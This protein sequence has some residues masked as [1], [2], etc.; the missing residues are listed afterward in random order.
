V[1]ELALPPSEL[2]YVHL[3][4]SDQHF[5]AF[6]RDPYLALFEAGSFLC[7]LAGVHLYFG[8]DSAISKNRR[9]L[10]TLVLARWADQRRQ[11]RNAI[12]RDIIPPGDFNLPKTEPGD[13]IYDQLTG[14]GLQLP[15]HSTQIGSSIATESHYYQIAFFPGET[16]QQLT[17]ESGVFDFDG[18]LVRTLWDE[19]PE[20]DFLAYCRYYISDHRPL[21]AEFAI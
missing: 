15:E 11:S 20:S 9:L 12:T 19:R 2:R 18:A 4:G 8:S 16:E 1:G 21:W 14:R 6:D 5:E 10:E 13:P 17:G 7:R 3:P